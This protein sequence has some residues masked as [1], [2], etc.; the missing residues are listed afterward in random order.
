MLK[1]PCALK[2]FELVK[3]FL[4]EEQVE[5]VNRDGQQPLMGVRQKIA[6][7]AEGN[8]IGTYWKILL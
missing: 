3:F 1:A 4:P 5:S 8:I 6:R 7:A 2:H